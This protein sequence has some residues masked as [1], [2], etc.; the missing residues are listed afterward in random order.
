MNETAKDIYN[1]ALRSS[2]V[3][4]EGRGLVS[5]AE[6]WRSGNESK[7]KIAKISQS[8]STGWIANDGRS[9]DYLSPC[10]VTGFIDMSHFDCPVEIGHVI[11]KFHVMPCRFAIPSDYPVIDGYSSEFRCQV[12]ENISNASFI[13]KIKSIKVDSKALPNLSDFLKLT[14]AKSFLPFW[15]KA[16]GLAAAEQ[17]AAALDEV[18]DGIDKIMRDNSDS[19]LIFLDLLMSLIDPRTFD[20]DLSIGLLSASIPVSEKIAGRETLLMKVREALIERGED[21]EKEL[22]GL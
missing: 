10:D 5:A 11:E 7:F 17:P 4:T 3:L 14:M 20:L 15:E 18:Y 12:V 19:S 16:L 9:S 22:I 13:P 2:R 21:P 6:Q 8:P 1:G